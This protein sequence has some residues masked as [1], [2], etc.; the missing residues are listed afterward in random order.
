MSADVVRGDC[1]DPN[2][3]TIV[4]EYAEAWRESL[5]H[6]PTTEAHVETN[7]RRHV[8]PTFG[9][10][11]MS[12]VLPSGVQARVSRLSRT[13]SPS[14]VHVIHGILAG[15]YKCAM[16]D[17]IVHRSPCEGTRLPRKLPREVMPLATSTVESLIGAAPARYR[18][19]VVLAAGTGVRQGE[20]FGVAQDRLDLDRQLLRVDQQ[21]ILLARRPPML[22]PPK[23]SASHRTIPLPKVVCEVLRRHLEQFPV[24]HPEGLIFTDEEG[25][26]LRR[27]RFSREIWRP[28]V[29]AAGAP[30]GT[31][32]HDLRHYYASLLI[33]HGESIKT[34][35]RR[36]GH[37]TAAETLDTYAHLWPDSDD[38]TREAIDS[39]L[40]ASPA[41]AES[42]PRD[43]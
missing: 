11:R 6:R 36:L 21:V 23:T 27:T 31:G 42:L 22:A 15:I 9:D 24:Q 33:R 17:R 40:E 30:R 26:A 13:L 18:A 25:Q 37:A 34:V 8:Y 38:R 7:L 1:V 14:T 43:E 41:D 10:R 29:A 4:R 5:V 16:R 2:E 20:C 39:V 19:A 12:S 35:Q 28:T 32:F 3:K